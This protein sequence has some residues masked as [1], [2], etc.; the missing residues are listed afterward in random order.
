M[1]LKKPPRGSQRDLCQLLKVFNSFPSAAAGAAGIHG[2]APELS[3]PP[4]QGSRELRSFCLHHNPAPS[5]GA[6]PD[7]P[8]IPAGKTL[9]AK[10]P[11]GLRCCASPRGDQRERLAKFG[12]KTP[13]FR[14][15]SGKRVMGA[16]GS[17]QIHPAPRQSSVSQHSL[18]PNRLSGLGLAGKSS[19]LLE[20][21]RQQGEHKQHL[22]IL[23]SILAPPGLF[24]SRQKHNRRARPEKGQGT[25]RNVGQRE[26]K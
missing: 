7:P 9:N 24:L 13:G 6:E 25:A 21:G 20:G 5:L 17:P 8:Q 4:S 11:P 1:G 12:W 16:K 14:G 10:P 18:I 15:A 23:N 3:L 19:S 2:S 22:H 26:R